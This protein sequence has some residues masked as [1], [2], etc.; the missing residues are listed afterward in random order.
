[1]NLTKR[2]EKKYMIEKKEKAQCAIGR[3]LYISFFWEGILAWISIF[4]PYFWNLGA[5]LYLKNLVG[6]RTGTSWRTYNCEVQSH[7]EWKNKTFKHWHYHT[8]TGSGGTLKLKSWKGGNMTKENLGPSF[9]YPRNI[10]TIPWIHL[11]N[12]WNICKI[13]IQ[14]KIPSTRRD[15]QIP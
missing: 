15:V 13:K 6:K 10:P 5:K 1:M 3:K 12:N 9:I 11:V 7:F 4:Q 14:S 2:T 8:M